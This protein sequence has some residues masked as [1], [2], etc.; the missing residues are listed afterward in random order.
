VVSRGPA[1]GTIRIRKATFSSVLKED[2]GY[3][4]GKNRG[5]NLLQVSGGG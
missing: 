5:K 2:Q 1:F 4:G 3:I